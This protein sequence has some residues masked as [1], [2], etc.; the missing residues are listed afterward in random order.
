MHAGWGF[1][2]FKLKFL[3]V[4][5]IGLGVL[6]YLRNAGVIPGDLFWPVVFVLGGLALLAKSYMMRRSW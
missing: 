5:L 6:W 4:G 3:A 1:W 2:E